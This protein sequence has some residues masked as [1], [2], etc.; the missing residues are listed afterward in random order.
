VSVNV[1]NPVSRRLWQLISAEA[2]PASFHWSSPEASATWLDELAVATGDG[3]FRHA[4]RVLR[5]RTGGRPVIAGGA[6][7]CWVSG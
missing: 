2:R 7:L 4:A 1:D 3:R 6:R 5:Q